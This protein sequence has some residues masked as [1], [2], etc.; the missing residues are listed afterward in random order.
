MAINDAD[1]VRISVRV[2]KGYVLIDDVSLTYNY[3]VTNPLKTVEVE[4]NKTYFNF[5]DLDNSVL[6]AYSVIARNGD[7]SS[8]SSDIVAVPEL[9]ITGIGTAEIASEADANAPVFDLQGRRVAVATQL[10]RLPK[11]IYIV[12]GRKVVVK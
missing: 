5:T 7:V 11:G 6:Y 12:N 10:N 4:G 2:P 8:I 3:E 9:N 1:S